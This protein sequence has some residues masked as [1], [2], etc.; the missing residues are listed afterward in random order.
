MRLSPIDP[1]RHQI[2]AAFSVAACCA[3][4]YENAIS[5]AEKALQERPTLVPALR[6]SV[7]SNAL[8]GRIAEAQK[9]LVLLTQL[10]PGH[11]I[12]A[13]PKRMF[14]RPEDFAKMVE[15]LRLAGMP[16]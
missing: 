2:A 3:G 12:S 11:R 10:V 14:R 15:G 4:E 7:I 5:W 9:R 6:S 16:E 8:A 13:F 1:D